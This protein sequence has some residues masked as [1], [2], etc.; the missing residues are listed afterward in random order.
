MCVLAGYPLFFP[1]GYPLYSPF[2]HCGFPQGTSYFP[3][4][5]PLWI[6]TGP[7]TSTMV[8]QPG[9]PLFCPFFPCE[10]PRGTSCFPC[11]STVGFPCVYV[12]I[13]PRVRPSNISST[14]CSLSPVHP[15]M[16]CCHSVS[17]TWLPRSYAAGA[18][19]RSPWVACNFP[20]CVPSEL[21][22]SSMWISF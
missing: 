1:T 4:M 21:A 18:P 13:S 17:I 9:Y 5:L 22:A 12:T 3:R 11:I 7:C 2:F 6:P 10:F 16:H 19:R 15:Q 20:I 14:I 8:P